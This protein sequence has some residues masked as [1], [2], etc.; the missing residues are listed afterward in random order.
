MSEASF[1]FAEWAPIYG[2]RG[3][4]PRA[5]S[6]NTKDCQARDWQRPDAEI[7]NGISFLEKADD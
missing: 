1:I 6:L 5:I 2:E 3:Y 4:C 7:A